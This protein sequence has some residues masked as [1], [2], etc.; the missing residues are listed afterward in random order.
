M[1]DTQT[2]TKVCLEFWIGTCWGAVNEDGSSVQPSFRL[3]SGARGDSRYG[4]MIMYGFYIHPRMT[5]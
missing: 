4:S 5:C 1:D 2:R 3:A